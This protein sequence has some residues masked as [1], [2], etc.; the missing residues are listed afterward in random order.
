MSNEMMNVP[1]TAEITASVNEP[2]RVQLFDPN[3]KVVM[4]DAADVPYWTNL[5]FTPEKLSPEAAAEELKV[6][7]QALAKA[8]DLYIADLKVTGKLN[9]SADGVRFA[10][11]VAMREVEQAWHTLERVVSG[12]PN[13]EPEGVT[14]ETSTGLKVKVDPG[15]V[16]LFASEGH[17]THGV[18]REVN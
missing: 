15:Q 12:L 16:K 2:A 10:T 5:G 8:V 14:M 13:D 11:F 7:L 9:H 1:H 18:M 4:V 6:S 17:P 3:G